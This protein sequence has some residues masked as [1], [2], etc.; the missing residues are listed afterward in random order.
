MVTIKFYC[1]DTWAKLRDEMLPSNQESLE[2]V[3][4]SLFVLCLEDYEP[5]TPEQVSR[6][7]LYGN[8]TNR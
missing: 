2:A 1:S 7:M 6:A 8:A 5:T 3:D 4:S